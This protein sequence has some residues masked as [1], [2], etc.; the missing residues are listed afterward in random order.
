MGA[1][2]GSGAVPEEPVHDLK[3]ASEIGCVQSKLISEYILDKA[4]E[5]SGVRSAYCRVGIIA[6]PIEKNVG[7]W[8]KDEYIPSVSL[9]LRRL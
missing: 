2:K 8:N 3:V 7:L 1:W 9:P 5:I 4:A 6:G